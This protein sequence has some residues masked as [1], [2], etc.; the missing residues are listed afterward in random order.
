MPSY[1]NSKP[2]GALEKRLR[3]ERHGQWEALTDTEKG[4]NK[5]WVQ[6]GPVWVAGEISCLQARPF[7]CLYVCVYVCVCVCVCV[8]V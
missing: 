1:I 5:L 2:P 7:L 4:L 6:D 8:C 3:G